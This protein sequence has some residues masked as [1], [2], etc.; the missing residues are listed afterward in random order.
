MKQ[1]EG[2]KRII[3][4]L[5]E[6]RI[7]NNECPSCGTPKSQWKR[8]TDWKCCSVPCTSAYWESGIMCLDWSELRLLAFERDAFTCVKCGKKSS[9]EGLIGDHITPISCGGE[10]FELSNVQTLCQ[11]CN[12][13]KTAQDAKIIAKFRMIEKIQKKNKTLWK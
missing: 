10:E 5:A 12:K 8:R 9:P 1:R 13:I 7:A 11:D 4:K 6:Q 2:Y 3:S